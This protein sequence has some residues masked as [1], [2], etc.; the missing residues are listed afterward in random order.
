MC[1][2]YACGYSFSKMVYGCGA[3]P[4]RVPSRAQKLVYPPLPLPPLGYIWIGIWVWGGEK[5]LP[6][7][8]NNQLYVYHIIYNA[9]NNH[10]Q[11]WINIHNNSMVVTANGYN[12]CNYYILFNY[13]E[14]PCYRNSWNRPKRYIIYVYFQGITVWQTLKK[15]LKSQIRASIIYHIS[16]LSCKTLL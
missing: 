4:I 16:R 13:S 10:T 7:Y 12:R 9:S 2:V 5:K 1:G 15:S 6:L 14:N 11:P 8:M 3:E